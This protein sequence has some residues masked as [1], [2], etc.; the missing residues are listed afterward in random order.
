MSISISYGIQKGGVGKSTSSGIT[1]FLLSRIGYKVLAVDLD[2]QGNLT[3]FLSGVEDPGDDYFDRTVLEAMLDEDATEYIDKLTDNLHLLP[4]NDF[5]ARM[6]RVLFQRFRADAPLA[7]INCLEPVRDN[8]DFIILD[9]PPALSDQ[10]I[11]GLVASDYVVV[12][13][14]TSKFCYNAVP[15]FLE[16]VEEVRIRYNEDLKVAGILRTLADAR[17]SDS[18]AFIELIEEDYPGLCFDTIIHRKAATGR[19][20]VTRFENNSELKLAVEQYEVFLKEL[21]ERVKG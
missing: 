4:S 16:L 14:E 12:M 5:T 3:Q 19:L 10:T 8:Y 2:S 6:P 11:N 20:P 17:R 18:K 13:F 7:L 15:R 9:L 21:L 1:S